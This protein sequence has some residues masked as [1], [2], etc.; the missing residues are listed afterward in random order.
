[1]NRKAQAPSARLFFVDD[2]ADG[3]PVA[4]TRRLAA[5]PSPPPRQA[6][7]RDRGRATAA[8]PTTPVDRRPVVAP[9]P[10]PTAAP[11]PAP[12]ALPEAVPDLP[13]TTLG[14]FSL[15]QKQLQALD[16][17]A[18]NEA[19]QQASIKKKLREARKERDLRSTKAKSYRRE[20]AL[21]AIAAK[22]LELAMA[23]EAYNKAEKAKQ[24]ARVKLEVMD[25]DTVVATKEQFRA[26]ASIR[27]AERARKHD[28]ALASIAAETA[29]VALQ[30]LEVEH[31]L[32]RL[33]LQKR[34]ADRT[35]SLSTAAL[36]ERE[37]GDELREALVTSAGL[38][39]LPPEF[40]GD[41]DDET[42]LE[43]AMASPSSV[44]TPRATTPA[45]DLDP[46]E[47]AEHCIASFEERRKELEKE[48]ASAMQEV[49]WASNALSGLED[50][51]SVQ[52]EALDAAA[53]ARA[54]KRDLESL[55]R[56]EAETYG[57]DGVGAWDPVRGALIKV[58][59][60]VVIDLGKEFITEF[61]G[62]VARSMNDECDKAR[63]LIVDALHGLVDGSDLRTLE[64]A[65]SE[66]LARNMN[67]ERAVATRAARRLASIEPTLLFLPGLDGCMPRPL[68]KMDTPIPP[69]PRLLEL[70]EPVSTLCCSRG[71]TVTDDESS[72][73]FIAV[74][75]RRGG[76]AIGSV[77]HRPNPRYIDEDDDDEVVACL[78]DTI[79]PTT[80]SQIVSL[81]IGSRRRR[82]CA[83]D[84]S[85][86]IRVWR[87]ELSPTLQ[88]KDLRRE[89]R[90][91]IHTIQSRCRMMQ[92]PRFVR[93]DDDDELCEA[94][95]K[96]NLRRLT[97]S[98]RCCLRNCACSMA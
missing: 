96:S 77:A 30:K 21:A 82:L 44:K 7:A 60:G 48:A 19:K 9:A 86:L 87:F 56:R 6:V 62:E 58:V 46:E 27:E 93:I 97:P 76:V 72:T 47:D 65:R 17:A 80:S 98:T 63:S 90:F 69:R 5:P 57:V 50:I 11:A 42:G 83:I 34:E 16:E 20:A 74:G 10:A 70:G 64:E 15:L 61:I 14:R 66:L 41:H 4:S 28:A 85:G 24:E 55:E 51:A 37:L 29:S 32:A 39:A 52:D 25:R 68:L 22:R 12:R 35:A 73:V 43:H 81:C 2:P 84:G 54:Q 91:D 78:R 45:R 94:G 92:L 40:P 36:L 18:A 75:G 1:M 13:P 67:N 53:L 79:Y 38:A 88:I 95:W 89:T 26:T 59:R 23:D 71:V 3:S 33:Q 49:A 8:A 31:E